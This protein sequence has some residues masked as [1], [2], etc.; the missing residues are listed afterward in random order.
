[1]VGIVGLGLTCALVISKML[2][3]MFHDGDYPF[4]VRAVR[5]WWVWRRLPAS[6]QPGESAEAGIGACTQ[7][8]N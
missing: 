5:A 6:P 4:P 1:M 7:N 2:Y 8:G 3:T